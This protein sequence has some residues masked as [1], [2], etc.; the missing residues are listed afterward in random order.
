LERYEGTQAKRLKEGE[1]KSGRGIETEG[2]RD[3]ERM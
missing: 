1:A 2:R 3:N